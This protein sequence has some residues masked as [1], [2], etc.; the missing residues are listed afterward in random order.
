MRDSGAKQGG[1]PV[2]DRTPALMLC[3]FPYG[4]QLM[5]ASQQ[6]STR[7]QQDMAREAI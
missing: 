5:A 4:Q 6:A 7:S 3:L 2:N 1:R